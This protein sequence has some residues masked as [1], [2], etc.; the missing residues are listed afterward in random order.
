MPGNEGDAAPAVGN[1]GFAS[2]AKLRGSFTMIDPAWFVEAVKER[3]FRLVQES[4]QAL[5]AG[6]GFWMGLFARD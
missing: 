5:T 4:Q 6:K 1:S 3:G 2:V